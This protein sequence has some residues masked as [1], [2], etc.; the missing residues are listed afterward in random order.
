MTSFKISCNDFTMFCCIVLILLISS[1]ATVSSTSLTFGF[2]QFSCPSA[3]AIVTKT[4]SRNPGFAAAL[5][6]MHFH[7]CFVRGCDASV[8]LE[9]TPENK[10]EKDHP[11]NNPSLRGFEV[12][13]EAK[14]QIEQECPNTVSCADIIAF[15]ARD[16]AYELGRIYYPVP[17]GRR[18]G[19]VSNYDEVAQNL[20][21]FTSNAAELAQTFAQKGL[22][23]DE[24]VT[25]SGAHSIGIAHCSSFMNRLY[26][27]SGTGDVDPSLDPEYA[28]FLK[29]KCR[30]NNGVD[31]VVPFDQETPKCLDNGYYAGLVKRR[32]LLGSDQALMNSSITEEM[33]LDNARDGGIW[34]T[35]FAMA[36]VH[37]GSIDVL[38]GTYGQIRKRCSFVN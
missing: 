17:A 8:L 34:A 28:A 30:P 15:A 12:I 31:L 19:L 7:D 11:A 21:K 38:T 27:F 18:D 14:S 24:M 35:K 29:T 32:G 3:E 33:V 26:N 9:S 5:I 13:N 6:R 20:P 1:M 2:Y 22:S 16:S 23:V 25:L 36:M 4:V 37:M 10:S